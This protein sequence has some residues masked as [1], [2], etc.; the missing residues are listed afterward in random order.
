MNLNFK[1]INTGSTRLV[2]LIGK[3]A[4]KIPRCFVKMDNS[5]NGR[6]LEFL[7]G[8]QAN[9]TEY[10]WSQSKI[11]DYL[12]PIRFSLLGSLIII[13][14]RVE[15]I[16]KNEFYTLEQFNFGKYEHKIDS[17]GKIKNRI[18]IIDYGN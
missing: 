16:S 15:E 18:V 4:I 14:D 5:F 8:W 12:N 1:F 6:I 2:F 9:R 11:Y 17:L 7:K 10:I 3:Y 13:Q